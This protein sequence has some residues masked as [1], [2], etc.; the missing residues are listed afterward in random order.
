METVTL[1][2]DGGVR[3]IEMDR[4]DALNAFSGQLM[5]DLTEAFLEANKDPSVRVAILTGAGRA[6]SAGADLTEMGQPP[7]KPKHGFPGLLE[8]IFD[9]EKPFIV[10]VNGVGAGV[11]ATICGLADLTYM[12][13]EARLRCPFSALG[14]TAE[15]ASTV[16]FPR[17]M[18]RQNAM[19]FLLASEWW[20]AQ[21]CV[22]AGL[23][24]KVLPKDELMLYAIGQAQKLAALPLVSL[25]KTKKLIMDPLKDEMRA[26]A[27]AENQGLAELVGG[28]ANKE[29]LAAFIE[30]RDPDFSG[31]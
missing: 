25:I 7:K 20:S 28:P 29:A 30:K 12:A 11:G 3:I 18:G 14:L 13:E 15:A 5:D 26:A 31:L 9:F 1:K 23:A 24:L 4:P 10:A 19:W 8:A 6:F 17:L 2:N 27:K 16:T 21:Q 22:E